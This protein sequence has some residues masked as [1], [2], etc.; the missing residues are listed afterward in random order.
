MVENKPFVCTV[1]DVKEVDSEPVISVSL[2]D[3]SGD[4]DVYVGS[5]LVKKRLAQ[6]VVLSAN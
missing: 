5:A 6:P 2:C 1:Y 4:D 3:T